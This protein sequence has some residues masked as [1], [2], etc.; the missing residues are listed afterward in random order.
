METNS[1]NDRDVTTSPGVRWPDDVRRDT[2]REKVP[3][4]D[5]ARTVA[6]TA[7]VRRRVRKTHSEIAL[8]LDIK[9][10]D[11]HVAAIDLLHARFQGAK[12]EWAAEWQKLQAELGRTSA[13][14]P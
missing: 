7:R 12:S 8:E 2:A 14:K 10:N 13:A 3:R 9:K 1:C 4:P 6:M 5:R 11:L